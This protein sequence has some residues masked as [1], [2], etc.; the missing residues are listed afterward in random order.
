VC[1]STAPGQEEQAEKKTE[2]YGEKAQIYF[3]DWTCR[4]FI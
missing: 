4:V 2:D 3:T 1:I